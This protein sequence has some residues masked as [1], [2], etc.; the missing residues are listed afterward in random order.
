[1][2]DMLLQ[3]HYAESHI[4]SLLPP[5][6][7]HQRPPES[8]GDSRVCSRISQAVGAEMTQKENGEFSIS[9]LMD[10]WRGDQSS[11]LLSTHEIMS[12]VT[13]K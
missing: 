9:E 12:L 5:N 11:T 13:T 4:Q 8:L 1:M 2:L 3:V 7:F 10:Q 6:G